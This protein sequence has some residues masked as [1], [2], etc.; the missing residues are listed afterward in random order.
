MRKK[1]KNFMNLI[2]VMLSFSV[3]I[4]SAD[5]SIKKYHQLRRKLASASACPNEV[6][7]RFRSLIVC[8]MNNDLIGRDQ[9]GIFVL[10]QLSEEKGGVTA[11]V[12]G[13]SGSGNGYNVDSTPFATRTGLGISVKNFIYNKVLVSAKLLD[14][15][16][17][18][19]TDIIVRTQGYP[20]ANLFVFSVRGHELSKI[21]FL[22]A[23]NNLR[24]GM[25]PHDPSRN[26]KIEAGKL[27]VP[28]EKI[29]EN[30]QNSDEGGMKAQLIQ[31]YSFNQRSSAI[32]SE[33]P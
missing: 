20:N 22:R 10:Q 19:Q 11:S 29:S 17:D 30:N 7:S 1:L 27:Y 14:M 2:L 8:E 18:G 15:D 16:A 5:A 25:L 32:S 6:S 13:I 3:S 26:L 33:H 31:V 21:D 12:Y 28:V 24:M 23:D 4:S 9:P